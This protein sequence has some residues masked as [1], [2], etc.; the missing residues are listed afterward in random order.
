MN[1]YLN[2]ARD[3]SKLHHEGQMYGGNT[4]FHGHIVKVVDIGELYEFPEEW[5]AAAYLHDILE[6]TDATISKDI[7]PVEVIEI[8]EAVTGVG[9]NRKE[10]NKDIYSK[11]NALT[12][13]GSYGAMA[14]KLADRI[15][16][17]EYS[18]LHDGPHYDMYKKENTKFTKELYPKGDT[19]CPTYVYE[20][21]ILLKL[22]F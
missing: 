20:L 1:N 9:S 6:D 19:K 10:R 17:V 15:A 13:R 11:I 3:L 21:W 18:I 14:V 4:Y 7:F 16:N 22:K 8:V 12:K 2:K 5:V